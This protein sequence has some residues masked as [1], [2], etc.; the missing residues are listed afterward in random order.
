MSNEKNPPL[1]GAQGDGPLSFQQFKLA[2]HQQHHETKDFK[3]PKLRRIY[4]DY[5]KARLNLNLQT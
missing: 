1:K 5:K 4:R 2:L 3:R